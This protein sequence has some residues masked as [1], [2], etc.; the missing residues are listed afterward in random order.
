MKINPGGKMKFNAILLILSTFLTGCD[1][2]EE[3]CRTYCE[4]DVLHECSS[5]V[6]GGNEL[7]SS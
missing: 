6:M 1:L 3:D 7:V 2:F 4:D 5:G